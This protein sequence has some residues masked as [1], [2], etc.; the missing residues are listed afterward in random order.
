M[1]DSQSILSKIVALREEGLTPATPGGA[2]DPVEE[3][4]SKIS[5]GLRQNVLLDGSLRRLADPAQPPGEMRLPRQLTART[6]RLLEQ[7]RDLLDTLR[8]LGQ[9][10]ARSATLPGEEAVG[11]ND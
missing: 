9:R 7:G 4:A 8:N 3:L 2:G 11:D 6:R 1:G 5:A 10:L